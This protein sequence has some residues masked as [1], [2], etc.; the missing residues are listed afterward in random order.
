MNEPLVGR[1]IL[2]VGCTMIV[3]SVEQGYATIADAEGGHEAEIPVGAL[4]AAGEQIDWDFVNAHRALLGDLWRQGNDGLWRNDRFGGAYKT[5]NALRRIG[6]QRGEVTNAFAQQTVR[7]FWDRDVDRLVREKGPAC[8]D[9]NCD[10]EHCALIRTAREIGD[11]LEE[12]KRAL[13]QV[14]VIDPEASYRIA[15]YSRRVPLGHEPL[16]MIVEVDPGHMIAPRLKD[17]HPSDPR[18]R[19]ETESGKS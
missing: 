12:A 3:R 5:E 2:D 17:N 7:I 13:V 10:H 14:N 19:T 4:P 6:S 9:L 18:Q 1:E 8:P 15:R 11:L 16:T